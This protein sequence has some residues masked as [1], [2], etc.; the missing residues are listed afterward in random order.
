L[1]EAIKRRN[2]EVHHVK[3]ANAPDLLF[4]VNDTELNK[5]MWIFTC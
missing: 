1:Y 3:P 2:I 5:C 4:F